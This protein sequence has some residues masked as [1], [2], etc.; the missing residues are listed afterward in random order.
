M[1]PGQ[2][3]TVG[4][5]T[6][7]DVVVEDDDGASW[8]QAG[9]GGL[10]SA[11][12]AL[13][14]SPD[15]ALNAV[16]GHDYPP[17]VMEGIR[18]TGIG[19]DGVVHTPDAHSIGL[20]LLY[21]TDGTRRQLEKRRSATFAEL[22]AIRRSPYQLGCDPVGVH[23]APQSSE[24][25]R[26]AL[27]HLRGHDVVRTLD[28]LIEPD[29]DTTP[30]LTGALFAGVDAFLPSEQEVLD[31]WGHTDVG[32][33]GGWLRDHGSTATVGIKRGPTG[34]DILSGDTVIRVPS[35]VD[36]VVDPTGAGDAF[37]GGFLAGLVRTCDP[38][39]AAVHG[40]V[41]ASFICETR[42]ALEAVQHIDVGVARR[43]A[44]TARASSREVS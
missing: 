6:I 21:E 28:L 15:V 8:K 7:D 25:Q 1:T 44:E 33:L 42:G 23:V 39:E 26:R 27:E 13:V 5:L 12:G 35:V 14:W 3:L 32:R 37:C 41:S 43:R 24:G 2:L 9:G 20:W 36:D 29:I 19:T 17:E 4:E 38:V 31:L 40:A 22:D 30:Y 18:A 34:V 10:Y 11:V 16:V